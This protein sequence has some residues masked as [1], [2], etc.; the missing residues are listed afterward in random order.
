MCEKN[1]LQ[2]QLQTD[3]VPPIRHREPCLHSQSA[4]FAGVFLVLQGWME[5]FFV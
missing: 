1:A 3:A 2:L 5:G 4:N